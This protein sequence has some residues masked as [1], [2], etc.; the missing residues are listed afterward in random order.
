M[1]SFALQIALPKTPG[2]HAE[3]RFLRTDECLS[4]TDSLSEY[5]VIS[6][7]APGADGNTQAPTLLPVCAYAKAGFNLK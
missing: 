2:S 6:M 5:H 7:S 4:S 1:Y 3:T